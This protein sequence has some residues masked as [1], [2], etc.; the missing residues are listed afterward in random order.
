ME[1]CI[2]FSAIILLCNYFQ[3][4]KAFHG[5][6]ATTTARTASFTAKRFHNHVAGIQSRGFHTQYRN[7]RP[8]SSS[9][10][11]VNMVGDFFA[12]ITGQ[13]PKSLDVPFET[14]LGGTSIDPSRDTV[15]LQCVFKA[16]RDGWSAIDFHEYCDGR[17][18]WVKDIYI[19]IQ[20]IVLYIYIYM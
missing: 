7:R 8:S 6:L 15:D 12:G 14:L 4:S 2:L 5:T 13:A 11:S 9:S 16:S 1:F 20:Y 10:S 3:L 19:Y 18:K 17:G